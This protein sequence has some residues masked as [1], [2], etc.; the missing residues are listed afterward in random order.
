[1]VSKRFLLVEGR[2]DL[3]V[4]SNLLEHHEV[5]ETFMVQEK[6]GIENLLS[7]LPVQ[8]KGSE[9]ERIGIVVDADS[10]LAPRWHQLSRILSDFGYVDLPLQPSQNG[11]IVVD[12]VRPIIGIW[13]MPNNNLPG[14]L[15]DFIALLIPADDAISHFAR[16]A[17]RSVPAA[18]RR[19]RPVDEAKAYVHTWLAWQREPGTP[20]GLAITKKYLDADSPEVAGFIDWIKRLFD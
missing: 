1:M 2:D 14:I 17:L 18:E 9:V 19:Y 4:V 12:A 8:L 3:M 20:L 13:I 10:D 7:V 16:A 11:T 15:E 6:G 5:P